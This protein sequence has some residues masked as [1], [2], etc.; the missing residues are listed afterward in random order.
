MQD[1]QKHPESLR[2]RGFVFRPRYSRVTPY[3]LNAAP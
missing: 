2:F 3:P 1:K